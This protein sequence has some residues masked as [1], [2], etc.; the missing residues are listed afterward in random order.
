MLSTLRRTLVLPIDVF[1]YVDRY[2]VIYLKYRIDDGI[3]IRAENRLT[4][5]SIKASTKEENVYSA[6]NS[7]CLPTAVRTDER[8]RI[9]RGASERGK[10]CRQLQE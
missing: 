10:R 3:D 8:D 2:L 1:N 9:L 5:R 4:R 7:D 6:R